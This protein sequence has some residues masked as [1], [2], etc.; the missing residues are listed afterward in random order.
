MLHRKNKLKLYFFSKVPKDVYVAYSGGV[1]S[2][3]LVHNLI[4]R[5]HNVCLLFVHHNTPWCDVE[6]GFTKKTAEK[7]NIPYK[8]DRIPL[9]DKSTSKESFWSKHRNAIFQKM[10]KPVLVGH[11]LDDALEWYLMSTFQ[12]T[13]KLLNYQNRNVIRPLL[14]TEKDKIFEYAKLFNVEFIKDPTNDDA[15]FNM[16]NNV[17]LNLLPAT[18]K[19]FPGLR[20]TVRR[21]IMEKERK[22]IKENLI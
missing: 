12:G 2:S 1:D 9:F 6:L 17:R 20:T 18:H 4:K 8:V 19:C 5:K 15:K 21:L 14:T 13:T 11:N 3:V 16:R 7:Y 22:N 10:D